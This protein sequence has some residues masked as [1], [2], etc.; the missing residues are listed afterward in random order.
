M[1]SHEHNQFLAS[2]RAGLKAA[3]TRISDLAVDD[4]PNINELV[5]EQ[6]TEIR[7]PLNC[8][9]REHANVT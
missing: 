4:E 5:M 7:L 1:S 8:S 3:Y 6:Q 9:T 2:G